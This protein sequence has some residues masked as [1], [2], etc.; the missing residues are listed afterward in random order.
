[1]LSKVTGII[2]VNIDFLGPSIHA[3]LTV[4][5]C[6]REGRTTLLDNSRLPECQW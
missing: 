1:M 6:L 3:R 4:F 5:T 2:R